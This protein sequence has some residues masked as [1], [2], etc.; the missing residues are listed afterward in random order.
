MRSSFWSIYRFYLERPEEAFQTWGLETLPATTGRDSRIRTVRIQPK[1]IRTVRIYASKRQ[2]ERKNG[3]F[4]RKKRAGRP[5]NCRLSA[6]TYI[7]NL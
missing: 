7:H 2:R 1:Q 6:A 5:G 3:G 4:S